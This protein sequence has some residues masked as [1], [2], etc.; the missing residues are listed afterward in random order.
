MSVKLLT[1]PHFEVLSLTGGCRGSS[2]STLVNMSNCWNLMPRPK[3]CFTI[4][5]SAFVISLYE[6]PRQVFSHHDQRKFVVFNQVMLIQA[7]SATETS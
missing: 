5:A 4:R 6:T 1:K 3:F 2:E 7:D